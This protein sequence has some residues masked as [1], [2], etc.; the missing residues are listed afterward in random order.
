LSK[1][2]KKGMHEIALDHVKNV[3]SISVTTFS[4]F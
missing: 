3:E 4:T 2:T 1:V